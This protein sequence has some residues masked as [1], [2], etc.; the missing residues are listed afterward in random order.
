MKYSNQKIALTALM[1]LLTCGLSGCGGS[2]ETESTGTDETVSSVSRADSEQT[3]APAAVTLPDNAETSAVEFSGKSVSVSGDGAEAVDGTVTITKGGIYTFTGETADGRI[4]VNAPDEEVTILLDNAGISC[5]GGSPIYIYKSKLT[6]IYL[7]EGTANT[8]TD[9]SEYTYSDSYSSAADEEPNACLYSKS[10]LVI[11]G[12]GSLVVN[13]NHNNGITSKD[14]LTIEEC[15]VTVT[16]VNNGINGK[17]FCV[18]KN[19]DINVTS[20]ADAIRSTNDSD[21]ALGY[22]EISDCSLDLNAGEDGIQAQTTL[23]V[24]GGT[25]KVVSGGG[26]GGSVSDDTSAKGLKSASGITLSGGSYTLDC[27]DDAIHSNGSVLISGGTF[28]ISTGDDGI[29]ADENTAVTDGTINII[30]SYEG[31]EGKTVEISGGSINVTASD[32]GINAAGGA[33]QSGFGKRGDSFSGNSDSYI[34]ISG[35]VITV[36]ASGDGVDSN[37]SL[38]VSGGEL[39]VS[40]PTNSGNGALDY[41]GTAAITGGIV[42]AAGASGMSQNFGDGSTQGSILLTFSGSSTDAIALKDSSGSTLA[43]YSPAKS[44]SCVLISCPD[45]TTGN[46]YTVEAC[47]QSTEVVMTSL[48]YGNSN[49]MGGGRPTG[50]EHG[51]RQGAQD[52]AGGFF[53]AENPGGME[54][55]L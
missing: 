35:G 37:G 5:S 30:K 46:T 10:D 22:I 31:I 2:S 53:G 42:V 4:I 1:A 44:Y 17:D 13:A 21:T 40:G 34:S 32:D 7:A 16:A 48:I 24:S 27:F 45:I 3:T 47:G 9:G 43:G 51:K 19:A 38:T 20:G 15:S 29:H 50:G 23:S 55:R 14:T 26:S 54:S 33:D 8:L 6:T 12:S 41:N 18:I 25:C 49:G 11:A 52:I 28:E 39:Y 36:D